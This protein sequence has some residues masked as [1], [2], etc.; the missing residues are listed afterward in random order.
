MKN[1]M[2]QMWTEG[3]LR[4]AMS[5]SSNKVVIDLCAG[6]Q[7]MRPVCEKLGL[8]YI[9]VDIEGDR[10]IRKLIRGSIEAK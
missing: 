8:E 10:N 5:R 9:T 3:F 1:A 6:W 7:S 2:P 4:H